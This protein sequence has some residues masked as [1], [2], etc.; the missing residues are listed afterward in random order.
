MNT[1]GHGKVAEEVG[2]PVL[3][4]AYKARG[5]E[6][7]PLNAFHLGNWLTDVQQAVDP[8]AINAAG[9]KDALRELLDELLVTLYL[10]ANGVDVTDTP[11]TNR[12]AI[13]REVRAREAQIDEAIEFWL[14]PA[15]DQPDPRRTRAFDTLRS[16]CRL[17]GYF[18][19]VHPTVLR[20]RPPYEP[21]SGPRMDEQAYLNV[22]DE[23][24]TQYY[25]HDHLDRPQTQSSEEP[26]NYRSEIAN[27]PLTAN[28]TQRPDLYLYLREDIQIAAGR[29][30]EVERIWAQEQFDLSGPPRPRDS[31]WHL[32]LAQFGRALHAVEDFFAHSNFV[33]HAVLVLGDKFIPTDQKELDTWSLRLQR[34]HQ[35]P[36]A[37]EPE[38]HIVT[39]TF[40]KRDT[41]ISLLHAVTDFFGMRIV[42][43]EKR[44]ADIWTEVRT[45]TDRR[46]ELLFELQNFMYE[47]SEL[48]ADP[49]A[50]VADLDN[51]VAQKFRQTIPALAVGGLVGRQLVDQLTKDLP[52]SDLPLLRKLPPWGMPVVINAIIILH[53]VYKGYTAYQLLR[54]LVRVL[55]D[56]QAAIRRWC[57]SLVGDQVKDWVL[58]QTNEKVEEA[59]GSRR[60]GCH[61]LLAKDYEQAHLYKKS[62]DCAAAV[63]WFVT[64]TMTREPTSLA[65]RNTTHERRHVDWLELLEFFL[66]HP[67]NGLQP[68]RRNDRVCGVVTHL[69]SDRRPIDNLVSLQKIYAPSACHPGSFTWRT[70]ANANFKT[71]GLSDAQAQKVINRALGAGEGQ[72]A[73]GGKMMF[74]PGKVILIP[75]QKLPAAVPSHELTQTLWWAEVLREETWRVLPGYTS[76]RAQESRAPLDPYTPRLISSDQAATRI[77]DA[78][79]LLRRREKEYQ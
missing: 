57:V 46:D 41:A 10:R 5:H 72:P 30:A 6:R 24:Y 35:L 74:K 56:P 11:V 14:A 55:E 61:S 28:A 50:A 29:L 65:P 45:A 76:G 40:D 60:I 39:G 47:V 54:D 2:L 26:V 19:F 38:E 75:D 52:R 12:S 16:I 71:N 51:R 21:E 62:Y 36:Q 23:L 70:I 18:L 48:I 79:R 4:S 68:E 13:V 7:V 17:T 53:T 43:P 67:A 69:V 33:E 66:G 78:N 31:T 37:S 58:F 22:F 27:G 3:L 8:V 20:P 73:R 49:R 15:S 9:I 64:S 77:A 1:E 34:W 63:H 42:H 44:L 32:A 59:I 25:P